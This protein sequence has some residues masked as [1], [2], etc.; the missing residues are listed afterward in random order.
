MKKVPLGKTGSTISVC[1]L[2]AMY[3]GSK[4]DE[5][6]SFRQM[7]LYVDHGGNHIDTA[8]KYA[9]WVQGCLGGESETVIGKWLKQKT[10]KPDLVIAS[11]VGFPYGEIPGSLKK[12]IIISECELSLR[13]LGLETIDLYYAHA[14]DENTSAE[15]TMEAFFQ[16]QKAGKIRHAGASNYPAW[17]LEKANAVAGLQGWVGYSCLQQRHTYLESTIRADFNNQIVL[18][19]EMVDYCKT[20]QLTLIAY[21]PL[22]GGAYTRDDRPIPSQYRSLISE[23][24][25]AALETLS[26]KIEYSQNQLVLAWMMLGD[27]PV[28][29]LI[30]G[31]TVSQLEENLQAS[32]ISLSE[33]DLKQLDNIEIEELRI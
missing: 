6:T 20:H 10:G 2:G 24:R 9:S 4:V 1:G 18:T 30:S 7:D 23:K 12:E 11:K 25:L 5:K 31:S 15:E 29:P 22:L 28:I 3:F 19:P 13:R 33:Q 32:Y 21:S 26:R 14:Y 27:P 16:L 17:R 8:N